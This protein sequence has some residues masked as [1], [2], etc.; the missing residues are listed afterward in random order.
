MRFLF[1]LLCAASSS[2]GM[3]DTPYDR[4]KLGYF[5]LLPLEIIDEITKKI[6]VNDRES[7]PVAQVESP[8]KNLCILVEI[9]DEITAKIKAQDPRLVIKKPLKGLLSVL[10]T[11]KSF[12]HNEAFTKDVIKKVSQVFNA[13]ELYAFLAV[14]TATSKHILRQRLIDPIEMARAHEAF[15]DLIADKEI[16]L[17]MLIEAGVKLETK[18]W[19][20]WNSE[21]LLHEAIKRKVPADRIKFLLDQGLDVNEINDKGHNALMTLVNRYRVIT[22]NV[23]IKPTILLL[24][25]RGINAN[26]KNNA[27]QTLKEFVISITSLQVI[28]W[29]LLLLPGSH[30]K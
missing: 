8:K 28:P 30:L 17:R 2:F 13:P 15:L 27:G 22:S 21:F 12:Y 20:R 25:V 10:R 18:E 4:Q 23:Q 3:L 7:L 6:I 11:S 26:H 29:P 14:K 5:G 1:I 9:P 19:K 24:I 16:N